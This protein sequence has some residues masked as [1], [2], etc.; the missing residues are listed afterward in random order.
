MAFCTCHHSSAPD[1]AEIIVNGVRTGQWRILVGP[2]AEAMDAQ[3]R[4]NPELAYTF[5]FHQNMIDGGHFD[6]EPRGRTEA[7]RAAA[8]ARGQGKSRL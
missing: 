3:V 1:A 7:V 4:A 8:E 6:I 2:D 5:G